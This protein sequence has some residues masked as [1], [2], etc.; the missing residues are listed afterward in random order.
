MMP[1]TSIDGTDITGATIDGTDVQEITVDGQTVFS[2]G[3][4]VSQTEANFATYVQN[5]D[6]RLCGIEVDVKTALAGFDVIVNP[7][8]GRPE[9]GIYDT[10][11]NELV[12]KPANQ[13]NTVRLLSNIAAN[14]TVYLATDTNG[15]GFPHARNLSFSGYP[16][17]NPDFEL[18]TGAR[19]DVGSSPPGLAGSNDIFTFDSIASLV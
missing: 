7:F 2:A 5:G 13:G 3:P 10:G 12:S 4:N 18:V 6:D 11:G 8:D 16:I 19:W 9:V 17:T 1:P 15:N 14:T